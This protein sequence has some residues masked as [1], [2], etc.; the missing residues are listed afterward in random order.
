[1]N[2]S[3]LPDL[4]ELGQMAK[5]LFG[6]LKNETSASSINS[7]FFGSRIFCRE[8]FW[9]CGSPLKPRFFRQL[10]TS[11]PE[12]RINEIPARRGEV[13]G[14]KIVNIFERFEFSTAVENW[15]LPRKNVGQILFLGENWR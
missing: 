4:P 8:V 12:I 15:L 14:E 5:K 3:Q 11:S 2:T 10:I 6:D 7:P 1:M 9:C 13:T